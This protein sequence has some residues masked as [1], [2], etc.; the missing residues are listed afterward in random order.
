[1]SLSLISPPLAIVLVASLIAAVTDIWKFRVYNALTLPLIATGLVYHATLGQ[2]L[3]D[4][5]LGMFFG[6]G[7]LIVLY[8]VGGMG[9]GDV[10]LMAGVGA[11]LGMKLTFLVFIAS[12][13]AAGIYA[14]GL[15]VINGRLVE[16]IVN[17]QILLHRLANV[18]KYLGSDERVESEVRRPDRRSRVIPFGAMVAV[19]LVATLLYL[20]LS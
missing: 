12:S 10:K 9:A 16:T 7:A 1:V 3:A 15:V 20:G 4:S 19:G 11:W 5:L 13:I 2:G 18:G 6:F 8:V 17:L 14:V